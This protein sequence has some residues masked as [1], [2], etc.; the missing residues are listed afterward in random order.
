M[1]CSKRSWISKT[2]DPASVA[3]ESEVQAVEN[4]RWI[5]DSLSNVFAKAKEG[6]KLTDTQRTQLKDAIQ[7]IVDAGNSKYY[8][9]VNDTTKEFNDRWLD[10]TVYISQ[11]EIDKAI[12]KSERTAKEIQSILPWVNG[13]K[14][15]MSELSTLLN[16]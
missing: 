13:F 14:G 15:F 4:A 10:P 8:E 7:T 12:P 2:I 11:K 5:I 16:Q 1:R 9:Y 6:T 3:R